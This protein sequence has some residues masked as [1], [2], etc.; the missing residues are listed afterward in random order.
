MEEIIKSIKAFL[1]DRASS[2]L[3][4]A[5]IVSWS[6]WNYKMFFIL[7]SDEKIENKFLLINTL[8]DKNNPIE[9][10]G[11]ALPFSLSMLL[12][13]AVYPILL[14]IF[15]IYVYPF[16]AKPVYKYNLQEQLKLINLK[17]ENEGKKLLNVEESNQIQLEFLNLQDKYEE[18]TK[19]LRNKLSSLQALLN[20][21][22]KIPSL[23][24]YKKPVNEKNINNESSDEKLNEAETQILKLYMNKGDLRL[25]KREILSQVS[26][27]ND[28]AEVAL[29]SLKDK[30]Y[31]KAFYTAP[32]TYS[33]TQK[34]KK[35]LIKNFPKEYT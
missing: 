22:E 12:D 20:E 3:I 17:K 26:K 21:Q 8:F 7:F 4:G 35:Y 19:K 18:E 30:D 1:Y 23:D 5:L 31:I 10:L 13:G 34:G 14:T 16:L 28:I 15:Y 29:S 24:N 27:H 32:T 25:S 2:P 11:L 6:F 33:I 9:F